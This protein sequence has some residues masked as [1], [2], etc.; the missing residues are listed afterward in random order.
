MLS[1][2]LAVSSVLSGFLAVGSPPCGLLAVSGMLSGLLAVSSVLSGLLALLL[3]ES[4]MLAAMQ[5]PTRFE[6]MSICLQ[7]AL[8]SRGHVWGWSIRGRAIRPRSCRRRGR[9][10]A[11]AEGWTCEESRTSK[12]SPLL[13]FRVVECEG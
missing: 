1:G 6:P 7:L 8:G 11:P 2:L 13:R 9:V 5:T 12:F 4:A 10:L 3:T